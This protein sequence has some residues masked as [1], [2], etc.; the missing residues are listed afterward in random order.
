M[1]VVLLLAMDTSTT[2]RVAVARATGDAVRQIGGVPSAQVL[3]RRVELD[4]RRHVELL[5]PAVS[6][7]LA[8][9]GVGRRDLTHVAVGTGPAPFTGLRVGITTAL[10]LAE[11]L[12]IPVGGVCSLD[13]VA[14]TAVDEAARAGVPLTGEVVA[15]TD[16][17]RREVHWARYAVDGAREPRRLDGPHVGAPGSVSPGRVVGPG[18]A[19]CVAAGE[20]DEALAGEPVLAAAGLDPGVLATLALARIAAGEALE[21]AV[22][23]YLRRPDARP[24][25]D[26]AP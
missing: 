24:L 10:V 13:A 23:R 16:A 3:A 20:D 26:A 2:V 17:K 22:P 18:A 11:A 7:V 25:A 5:V 12:G 8:A 6:A 19:L 1:T 4:A 15:A 21:P 9:A 14:A